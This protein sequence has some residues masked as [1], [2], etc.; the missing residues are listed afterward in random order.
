MNLARQAADYPSGIGRVGEL[1]TPWRRSQPDL[2]GW[3]WYYLHGLCHG[4]LLTFRGHGG[5]VR[6]VAWS[7]D[8]TRLASASWDGTVKVW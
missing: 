3:E 5:M 2:R 1:L 7:P 6:A 8:G 4:G